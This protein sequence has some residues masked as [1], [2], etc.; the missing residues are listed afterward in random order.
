MGDWAQRSA[1]DLERLKS[2][3]VDALCAARG[4]DPRDRRWVVED[5]EIML[6]VAQA[7]GFVLRKRIGL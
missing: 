6:A 1:L 7:R 4:L 2:D 5:L 3:M